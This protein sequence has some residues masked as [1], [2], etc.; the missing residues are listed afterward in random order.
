MTRWF[1][2]PKGCITVND[3]HPFVFFFFFF[4]FWFPRCLQA[5]M[6][7]AEMP[8]APV[9]QPT[10]LEFRDPLAYIEVSNLLLCFSFA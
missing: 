1:H 2:S 3:R 5:A 4:F 8:E 7:F 10:E 9:F 6:A